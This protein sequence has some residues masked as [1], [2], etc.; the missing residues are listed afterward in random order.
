VWAQATRLDDDRIIQMVKLGL[1]DEII[2]AKIRTSKCAFQVTDESLVELKKAGVSPKVQAAMI[3]ASTVKGTRVTVNSKQLPVSFFIQYEL[4]SPM[5]GWAR[6]KGSLA[7]KHALAVVGPAPQIVLDLLPGDDIA[8]FT[9][10]Q[11]EVKDNHRELLFTNSKL[12]AIL[13]ISSRQ[14]QPDKQT[15]RQTKAKRLTD[16]R[17]ELVL[18]APLRPGEYLVL[19]N[20]GLDLK[21]QVYAQGYAFAVQ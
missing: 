14:T 16:G 5:F 19:V 12:G 18:S 10:V 20:T 9:L 3:D 4:Q 15:I 21:A 11:L 13:S 7:G 8:N 2:I 6:N 17:F 1:D